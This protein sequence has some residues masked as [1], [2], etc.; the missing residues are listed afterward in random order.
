[1]PRECITNALYADNC[2]RTLLSLELSLGQ[3]AW[4]ALQDVLMV[5]HAIEVSRPAMEPMR[6]DEEC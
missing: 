5:E 6:E 2:L 3:C 4:E 1:M